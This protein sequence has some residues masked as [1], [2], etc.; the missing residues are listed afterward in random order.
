MLVLLTDPQLAV[1]QKQR[2]IRPFDR[3]LGAQNRVLLDGLVNF[4]PFADPGR[5]DDPVFPVL[6]P[7]SGVDRVPGRSLDVGDDRALFFQDRVYKRAFTDIRPSNDAKR[8]NA[9]IRRQI[10]IRHILDDFVKQIP[11]SKAMRAANRDRIPQSQLVKFIRVH[12]Q[13]FIVG[14]VDRQNNRLLRFLQPARDRDVVA[15]DAFPGGY[16]HDDHI[17]F[18][19]GDI[20]L[21]VDFLGKRL[22]FQLDP[23]CVNDPV[24]LGQP[25]HLSINSI[26]GH[27]RRVFDDAFAFADQ[28][29]KNC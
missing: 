14:F 18:L 6:V 3:P 17:R 21:H 24:L 13:G 23:A 26:P 11:Q 1:N 27:A 5:V 29:V 8:G 25:L 22:V 20:D 15:D 16:E 10:A 7:E 19:D 4:A 12:P 9:L 28:C 2:D